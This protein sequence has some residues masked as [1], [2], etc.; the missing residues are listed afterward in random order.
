MNPKPV[1]PQVLFHATDK[2]SFI[3]SLV[4]RSLGWHLTIPPGNCS[5]GT[6]LQFT[7]MYGGNL[8]PPADTANMTVTCL[9]SQPSILITTV[10]PQTE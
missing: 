9:F 8:L 2:R 10:L 6:V 7:V 4:I 5:L 3:S 1:S